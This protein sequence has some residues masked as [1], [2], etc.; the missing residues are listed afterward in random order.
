MTSSRTTCGLSSAISW[1]VTQREGTPRLCCKAM[2]SP[3]DRLLR[4]VGDEE[5]IPL[6][7]QADV[8]S[9]ALGEGL[10][11]A[12]ALLGETDIRLGGE[13]LADAAGGVGG[14]A[15]PDLIALQDDHVGDAPLGQGV[16]DGA[17]H[18]P[19]A[20]DDDL[21]RWLHPRRSLIAECGDR[22]PAS[23][24]NAESMAYAQGD[25][26]GARSSRVAGTAHRERFM[27][28]RTLGGVRLELGWRRQGIFV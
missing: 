20:D 13:L 2:F 6:L 12:D 5:E 26:S 23:A 3:E 4:G 19:G 9:E 17:A 1:G 18:D 10:P 25:Q 28:A 15:A 8:A 14:G 24:P 21:G 7:A 27:D 22:R 16:G 11:D